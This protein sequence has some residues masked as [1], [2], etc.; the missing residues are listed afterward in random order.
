MKFFLTCC[1]GLLLITTSA[2]GAQAEPCSGLSLKVDASGQEAAMSKAS[3]GYTVTNIGAKTCSL[4]GFP[5]VT[6]L[7]SKGQEITNIKVADS[8]SSYF[9]EDGKP[10]PVEL[11]PGAVASFSI[12]M[13]SSAVAGEGCTTAVEARL[14]L[15]HTDIPSTFAGSFTSCGEAI[16]VTPLRLGGDT[17]Q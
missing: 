10:G 16:T 12:E 11:E 2:V 4:E 17:I 14:T 5:S 1:F 8:T 9:T 13:V 3:Y 6:L 15:P 7:D